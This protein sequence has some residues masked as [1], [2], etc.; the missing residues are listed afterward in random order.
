[1]ALQFWR[2]P[3]PVLTLTDLVG[4]AET[5]S[6]FVAQITLFGYVKTRAGTRYG[7]LMEDD[8]FANSVNIAKWEIYLACL[9]DLATYVAARVGRHQS[10]AQGEIRALAIHL[11]DT[12]TNAE[13]IPVVRPQGFDDIRSA[14]AARA[15][16]TNWTD[17]MI[18]EAAFQRSLSALVEWA[19]I[20]DE[21][22]ID[23]V[24][25]VKNS[26]RFKWKKV[27]DQLE[28]LLD[29]DAVL[30]DWRAQNPPR[31]SLR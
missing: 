26:M 21:L 30:A 22:K 4:F 16:A 6:K 18:G 8:I 9:C 10:A 23:D 29:A 13:E 27:R 25:I 31:P 11:V 1:M 12:A 3:P 19:P 24:D 5:R 14:F 2:R 17:D 7:S 20:A 28:M 15:E